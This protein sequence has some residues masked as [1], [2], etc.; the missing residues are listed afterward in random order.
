M[1]KV[2]IAGGTGFIGEY[3]ANRFTEIGY[4]VLIVSRSTNHISWSPLDLANAIDNSELVI[5]LAGKSI[6]CRHN[7]EN[8][9]ALLNS[10][11][12]STNSIGNAIL[13]CKNPP[14]LWVNA[15]GSGIYKPTQVHPATENETELGTNFLAQLVHQWEKTFFQFQLPKTRQIALRTS[16][17]LGKNGGALKPLVALSKVGL[18][19]KQASGKQKSS[20]I[21]IEDYFQILLFLIEYPTLSGII[22]CTSPYSVSNKSFMHAIRQTLHV[23][24]GIPAPEFA[25]RIGAKLIGVESS[26]L[27]DS[28]YVAP[29][30]LLDAGF[31]FTYS[32]LKKALADIL[33]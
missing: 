17:V 18:G 24:I 26:L 25:I 21:H 1:E 27:L 12:E 33:N 3:I 20:W 11:I 5:N 30:R 32:K 6:N 19:G 16:V 2:V 31:H 23:P 28:S 22:N 10:R 9:K 4:T 29:K 14:K 8:K 7:L 13:K 15:S